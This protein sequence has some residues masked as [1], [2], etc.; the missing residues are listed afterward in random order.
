MATYATWKTRKASPDGGSS[1]TQCPKKPICSP[2]Q[3]NS[4]TPKSTLARTVAVLR[5]I[6]GEKAKGYQNRHKPTDTPNTAP[7]PPATAKCESSNPAKPPTPPAQ[8]G[9][10]HDHHR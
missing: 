10:Q 8:K 4:A 1:A 9:Q 3:R 5:K 6:L 2:T 7:A